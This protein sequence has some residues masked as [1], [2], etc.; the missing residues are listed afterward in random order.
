MWSCPP[1]RMS[2][3]RILFFALVLVPLGTLLRLFR[4]DLMGLRFRGKSLSSYF[5]RVKPSRTCANNHKETDN[6][7]RYLHN[8][9]LYQDP[10]RILLQQRANYRKKIHMFFLHEWTM[11]QSSTCMIVLF[12]LRDFNYRAQQSI[13]KLSWFAQV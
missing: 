10:H 1:K 13:N 2:I 6:K 12:K 3:L 8:T 9:R 11:H 4:I 7:D 5:Q